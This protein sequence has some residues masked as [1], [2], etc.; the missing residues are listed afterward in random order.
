M[1]LPATVAAAPRET[2]PVKIGLLLPLTGPQ[3]RFGEEILNGYSMAAE[4]I[5]TQGGMRQ[6]PLKGRTIKFLVEDTRSKPDAAGTA[7]E[8][9]ITQ[10][11]VPLI[12][13]GYASMNVYAVAETANRQQIPYLTQ[14]G[15]ADK[16]TEQ[17]WKWTFRMN[18]P[19]SAY[20]AGLKAF[21]LRVVRPKTM[22]ILYERTLFGTR[23]SQ[24]I[25]VWD[26]EHDI[27][28]TN[29]ESYKEGTTDFHPLLLK[30]KANHP[31]VVYLASDEL[32]GRRLLDQSRE[33][34]LSPKLFAGGAE[35][36]TSPEFI[37]GAGGAAENLVSATLWAADVKY[38]GAHEFADQ[39]YQRY[40]LPPNYH[41]AEGY[42]ATYV[43]RDVLERTASLRNQDLRN[44]FLG[45]DLMTVFG[46][47]RFV[48]DGRYTNQNP[49]PTLM[50]QIQKERPV[51]VWPEEVAAAP[52]V[53]PD[54]QAAE[55]EPLP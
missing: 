38:P 39:Y 22:A 31:D 20:A 2:D 29:Y 13:G 12:A 8:K 9:L 10:D 21:L 40:K 46:P 5:N 19:A 3:A 25:N 47:V 49:L 45:T 7:A 55:S 27:V 35:D 54:G 18:P 32:D 11:H 43:L 24:A 23:T 53:I 44:S 28:V 33:I 16:I 34:G 41:A 51:T 37:H 17:G 26:T 14:T 52:Y 6:G 15:A 42:A 48:A 4:E 36:F 50:V 30:V 1:I